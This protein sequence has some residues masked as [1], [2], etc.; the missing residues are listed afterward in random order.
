MPIH[1]LSRRC[2]IFPQGVITGTWEN[3]Q[4]QDRFATAAV[5]CPEARPEFSL[6]F[7]HGDFKHGAT[8]APVYKA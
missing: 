3:A 8:G 5:R 4:V 2:I 6:D 1:E 7:K